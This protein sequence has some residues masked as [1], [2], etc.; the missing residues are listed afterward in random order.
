[1]ESTTGACGLN[2][3]GDVKGVGEEAR[4]NVGAGVRLYREGQSSPRF[5]GVGYTHVRRVD[6][7]VAAREWEQRPLS[8]TYCR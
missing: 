2:R 6:V 3:D 1:M 7:D 5:V 4:D 8:I